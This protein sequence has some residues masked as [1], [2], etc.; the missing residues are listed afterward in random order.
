MA[1]STGSAVNTYTAWAKY[2]N[3]LN[4][5]KENATLLTCLRR[6]IHLLSSLQ[7]FIPEARRSDGTQ[8]PTK[9]LYAIL[10]GLLRHSREVQVDSVNFLDSKDSSF[11]S[12]SHSKTELVQPKSLPRLSV[13]LRKIFSGRRVCWIPRHR[14]AYKGLCSSIWGKVCCLR[15]G[16]EQ[17]N[18][19]LSQFTHWRA[20]R[21]H[22]TWVRFYQL[23]VENKCVPIFIGTGKQE[24]G[25]WSIYLIY[26]TRT[27]LTRLKRQICS[28]VDPWKCLPKANIG[29]LDSGGAS[30]P[31]MTWWRRCI[32]RQALRATS[33]TIAPEIPSFLRETSRRRNSLDI[34]QWKDFINTRKS[35]SSK[36]K[37]PARFSLHHPHQ[38]PLI[39]KLPKPV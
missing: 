2:R 33:Q 12:G 30:T 27:S 4:G 32:R 20:L 7:C 15:G 1:K 21:V 24:K 9:T 11:V 35:Q 38:D 26:T 29:I 5:N 22:W 36:S 17:R 13:R 16:K 34:D 8:Y 3:S 31:W 10:C 28:T 6:S 18:L 23:G 19:K 37:L 14:L 39:K 25:A